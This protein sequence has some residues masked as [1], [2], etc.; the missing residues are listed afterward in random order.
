MFNNQK[1]VGL[2]SLALFIPLGVIFLLS[3]NFIKVDSEELYQRNLIFWGITIER[4]CLI[5]MAIL[6]GKQHSHHRYAKLGVKLSICF[7]IVYLLF[8]LQSFQ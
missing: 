4:I 8:L 5:M 7:L 1:A 6:I 3:L 2:G